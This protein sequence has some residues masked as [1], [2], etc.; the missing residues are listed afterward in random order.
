MKPL[1]RVKVL[2]LGGLWEVRQHVAV[3]QLQAHGRCAKCLARHLA[4][5][6]VRNLRD[7]RIRHAW[8][9]VLARGGRLDT[10]NTKLN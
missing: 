10:R 2:V 6:C 8:V 5:H 3:T 1:I 9:K 7:H 4:S